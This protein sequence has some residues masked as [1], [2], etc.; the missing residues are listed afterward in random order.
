MDDV[1]SILMNLT[2]QRLTEINNTLNVKCLWFCSYQ[3]PRM[4]SHRDKKYIG[5]DLE[6]RGDKSDCIRGVGFSLMW[7][8]VFQLESV[9][10][11]TG[12]DEMT[13]NWT[14]KWLIL[15]DL[16]ITLI[17][18]FFKKNLF[19]SYVY[20]W[21]SAYMCTPCH[22][23]QKSVRSR[24]TGVTEYVKAESWIWILYKSSK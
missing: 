15:Y 12:K 11:N 18:Y 24:E 20:V 2:S 7:E 17:F 19:L 14:F 13:P 21:V 8:N 22:G 1:Y 16:N 23:S 4:V 3:T 9:V 6:W 10:F 5:G